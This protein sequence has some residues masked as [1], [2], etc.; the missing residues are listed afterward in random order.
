[1]RRTKIVCTIGPASEQP[2]I[3][4]QM[5]K[6]GMDVARL[7]FSHGLHSEHRGRIETIRRVAAEMGRQVA[8]MLDTK[9]PEIRTGLLKGGEIK[10]VEGG[11]F[12][13]TTREIEGNQ[14]I[15]SISWTQL[16]AE[17]KPGQTV[18]IDDGLIVLKVTG[19]EGTEISCQII[20]GGVLRNR[21]GVHVPGVRVNLPALMPKDIEDI[22]FGIANK[23]DFIAASFVRRADDVLEI[24][25][26]LE[27]NRADID[28]IAKI[29]NDEGV[30]TLEEIL[31]VADGIMVARGDL[32]VDLPAEEVPLIQKQI[33]AR[34]NQAG[35][36]VITATQMLDSMIRN[37]RPTR[38]EASDVANAIFDGT[39][40]I[41]LS[42]ETAVGKYPVEAVQTM[43]RIAQRAEEALDY[44]GI[45]RAKGDN[46]GATIT[47]AISHAT[48]TTAMGL[49]ATA[50]IS[51]SKS[52]Y[53]ARM[54][55]KYRPGCPII[56]ATPKEEVLRRLSIVWGVIP[57]QV[58]ETTGTDQMIEEATKKSLKAGLIKCGDLV[59]ITAGVPVGVPGTTNLIKVHIVGEVIVQGT[60][61]GNRAI[62]GKVKV[63]NQPGTEGLMVEDGDILVAVSTDC[64]LVP[65][66]ERAGAVITEEGGLTSHAAI[67]G[68]NLGVPVVVGVPDATKRLKDG[69]IVTVDGA[70]GLVYRGTTKVL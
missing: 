51:S 20:T 9:G 11:R 50:I 27:E 26:L 68:L 65:A 21:K 14:E 18:L 57:I 64:D 36:P 1:M 5:I 39:D 37:P 7:N 12:T 53:T 22:R 4:H 45:L 28:I 15:V 44:G 40:A 62:T 17:V 34:C 38:A 55:S 48:C 47:D 60:G 13:L 31:R 29:E 10:L 41:M 66:M 70:R 54:V 24:R 30:E 59:V 46:A 56:A 19:V 69:E 67:V 3:L 16:A 58:R 42:G 61:I 33:I 6:S 25:R 23:V 2:E 63:I 43:A 49:G 35:K 32:G 8:I 52:G